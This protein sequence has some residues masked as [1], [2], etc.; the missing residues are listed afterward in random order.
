MYDN[1]QILNYAHNIDTMVY[2]F[3]NVYSYM[4]WDI[5]FGKVKIL[6]IVNF[7]FVA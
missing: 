3:I 5:Y 6:I 7:I 2:R 1:M 4:F